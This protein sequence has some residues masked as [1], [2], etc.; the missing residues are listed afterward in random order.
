MCSRRESWWRERG[1]GR[2]TSIA[3]PTRRLRRDAAL[4]RPEP[5]RPSDRAGVG[6]GHPTNHRLQARQWQL[7]PKHPESLCRT[8]PRNPA[9]EW[10]P[11]G[12]TPSDLCCGSGAG[13]GRPLDGCA[14]TQSSYSPARTPLAT[15]EHRT[16]G[17]CAREVQQRAPTPRT[18]SAPSALAWSEEG[19]V[20]RP[21]AELETSSHHRTPDRWR[22]VTDK[23]V[24]NQ[25]RSACC[26]DSVG[27]A[28]D[29]CRA[30]ALY[31]WWNPP[32]WNL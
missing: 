1:A 7:C 2:W 20:G 27:T 21:A 29:S 31:G 4:S 24:P 6:R 22:G 9:F 30:A 15:L 32:F 3:V 12:S 28:A 5:D 26:W 11:D 23:L 13:L 25:G 19:P 17:R 8:G 18:A 14:A 16:S 10:L